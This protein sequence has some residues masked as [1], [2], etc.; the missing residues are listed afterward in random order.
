MISFLFFFFQNG[1][2]II[3]MIIGNKC[4]RIEDRQVS[5]DR[6]KNVAE[7]LDCEFMEVSAKTGENVDEA[8]EALVLCILREVNN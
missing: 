3:V 6:G 4:D 1:K 8:F 5:E 2:N 7:M